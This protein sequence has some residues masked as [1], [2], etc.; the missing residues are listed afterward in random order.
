MAE[1]TP[2]GVY[3]RSRSVPRATHA[4]TGTLLDAFRIYSSVGIYSVCSIGRAVVGL[5]VRTGRCRYPVFR[6]CGSEDKIINHSGTWVSV[7]FSC[8]D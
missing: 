1:V 3:I 5:N 2:T 7:S 4:L 8:A 6:L